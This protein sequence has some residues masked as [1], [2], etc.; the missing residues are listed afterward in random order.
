MENAL[1]N[2][3]EIGPH[4]N[5][6]EGRVVMRLSMDFTDWRIMALEFNDLRIMA[7]KLNDKQFLEMILPNSGMSVASV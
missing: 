5:P 4:D 6:R 2:E 7:L 1:M 3:C